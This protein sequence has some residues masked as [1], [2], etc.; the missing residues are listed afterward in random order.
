MN[1]VLTVLP[2]A[3]KVL[4][5]FG[6][7]L[8]RFGF[9]VAPEQTSDFMAAVTLLGPRSM[10][11]IREAALATLSPPPDRR[12]E[13]DA[14]FRSYFFGETAAFIEG[15]A[16]EKETQVKD[17][18][19]PQKEQAEAIVE[20]SSGELASGKER[21][22]A[23]L[24]ERD[25]DLLKRFRRDLKNAL[26]LR[27]S[28]RT[29][30]TASRGTLDLR[31][32]LRSIVRADG[33][34]PAPLLRRRQNIPR[35]LMLLI[36]VSGSMKLHTADYLAVAH[37]AV[38]SADTAEVFTLG[39]RLT[40]ITPSLR[41]RTCDQA[42]S[43]VAAQV[44]DWDGGTRIGPTLLA[45]LSVP[46]FAAFARGAA[47]V[48][49]SDALE[50]GDHSEMELAMRRLSARAFRLSL[51]TPLAGDPRFR[52]QTTALRAVLPMLD[53]LVDGS[54]IATLTDFILSLA[55]PAATAQAI[56]RE[57]S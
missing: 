37:A 22:S 57:V 17:D 55:R 14:H 20:D 2:Q 24:F 48:I 35:R 27:R 11:D 41:V 43:R 34:V 12:A 31:R 1:G 38:Q 16:D 7:V 18:G 9:A 53:D 51:C 40:R 54:S 45:L 25:D 23:R 6:R 5:G 56:W 30:R 10:A 26:P 50:R 3:A 19:G 32:S 52:P 49:L 13:F 39:T 36:D 4:M 15:D 46:R 42:L 21:L 44:D 29:I 28:F 47:V 8:R 33:D